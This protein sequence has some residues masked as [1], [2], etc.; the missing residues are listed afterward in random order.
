MISEIYPEN[1][2]L[3]AF[4]AGEGKP[5]ILIHGM[6]AS[7][8]DWDWI[9]PMLIQAGFKVLC[10]DLLGHGE[11][12]KP[13][14]PKIYTIENLYRSLS[15]WI[16]SAC[17]DQ[18][19]H[20]V[21][22]SLGGYLGLLY[23]LEHPQNIEKMVLV[24][25]F[26]SPKQIPLFAR[27]T[28]RKPKIGEKIFQLATA[29]LVYSILG[30][31]QPITGKYPSAARWRTALDYEQTSP[32]CMYYLASAQDLSVRVREIGISTLIIW[33]H[34]DLVLN[35]S[36]Y[37]PLVQSIPNARGKSIPGCGH[38]PHLSCI[39][40]FNQAILEFFKAESK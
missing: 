1:L 33:G 36:C 16:E 38:E 7:H 20:L 27:L 2:F 19:F 5:V 26:Y 4:I 40:T 8:H 6:A 34:N 10:P 29:N 23:A 28:F 24:S 13:V 12:S 3:D 30:L 14:N 31:S 11:S 17:W 39:P 25:P 37:S 18:C 21:G 22:H 9:N 15:Q 32:L 35:P